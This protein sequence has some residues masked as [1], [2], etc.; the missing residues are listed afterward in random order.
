MP[1]ASLYVDPSVGQED[2]DRTFQIIR[3]TLPEARPEIGFIDATGPHGQRVAIVAVP[4]Y[5]DVALICSLNLFEGFALLSPLD[6][7]DEVVAPV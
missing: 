3:D 7:Y 2:I 6:D 5:D 4:T 1:V